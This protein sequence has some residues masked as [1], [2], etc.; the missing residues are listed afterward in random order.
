MENS[1]EFRSYLIE[2]QKNLEKNTYN[3]FAGYLSLIAGISTHLFDFSNNNLETLINGYAWD[4]LSTFAIYNLYT[5]TGCIKKDYVTAGI[6][7][8]VPSL[9]E[10]L[11]KFDWISGT[12]DPK[13]FIVYGAAAGLALGIDKTIKHFSK[14]KLLEETSILD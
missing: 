4:F 9:A 5:A 10:I 1:N 14:K 12:Y 7:F 3:T 11:Q 2:I 13:D 6:A 8:G